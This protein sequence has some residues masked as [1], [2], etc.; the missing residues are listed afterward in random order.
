MGIS[1]AG[2]DKAEVLAALYDAAKAQGMGLLHFTPVPMG[3]SEASDLL[4][5]MTYFDYV[6]GRVMKVDLSTDDLYEGLYDRDNGP[7]A[8]K[9]VIDMLR[10]RAAAEA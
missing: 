6:K 7:G 1:I 5:Q 8:A 4:R 3:I 2:L 9:F 10:E